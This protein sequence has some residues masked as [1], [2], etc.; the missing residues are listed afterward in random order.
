MEFM[1][2]EAE[3]G[4]QALAVCPREMPETILL[5]WNIPVMNDLEFIYKLRDLP[6]GDQPKVVFCATENDIS[7][8]TRV[9]EA[10]VD[11][12]IMKPFDKEVLAVKFRQ[13]RPDRAEFR[14]R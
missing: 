4:E 12:Y 8:I 13:I 6:G 9:L 1:V 2:A 14:C 5:D 3:H 10:G 7:H 11:E